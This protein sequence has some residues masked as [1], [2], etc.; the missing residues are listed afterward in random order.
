LKFFGILIIVT[1]CLFILPL[2]NANPGIVVTV[3]ELNPSSVSPGETAKCT[4]SVESLSTEDESVSIN[5]IGDPV[6]VFDWTTKQS[7]VDSMTV[8][9]FDLE[10]TSNTDERGD[11]FFTV[12][13]ESWPVGWSYADAADIGLIGNSSYTTSLEVV[14]ASKPPVASFSYIPL[15]PQVNEIMT[16]NA[17]DCSDP[18]GTVVNYLWNFGDGATDTGLNITVLHSY[19]EEG[20][21]NVT[22]TV[23][24]EDGLTDTAAVNIS[25][26]APMSSKVA[27]P[28]FTP[29]EGNYTSPQSVAL[30]CATSGSTI[31]YTTDGSIPTSSSTVYSSPISVDVSTIITAKA[32]KSGMIDSDITTA[33]YAISSPDGNPVFPPEIIYAAAAVVVVLIIVIVVIALKKSK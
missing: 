22:L 4:I 5:V 14:T 23:T 16:F 31:L 7:V 13:C 18:D 12:V 27:N 20:A 33:T 25:V 21:Y 3:S 11:Y 26:L 19:A 8:R 15:S 29:P 17:S 9:K 10:V 28:T 24:D 2:V 30:I 1:L 32:F 6:L